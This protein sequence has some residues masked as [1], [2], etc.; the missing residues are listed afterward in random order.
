MQIRAADIDFW[1]ARIN[2][3][4]LN[5]ETNMY[6]PRVKM[7]ITMRN[8]ETDIDI[9]L[10]ITFEGCSSDSQLNTD[11][12]FPL[13]FPSLNL[14]STASSGSQVDYNSCSINALGE[15]KT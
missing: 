4:K 12:I 6:P 15:F 1:E 11:I 5:H 2:V 9:K 7:T 13:G 3:M 14:S 10:P 8:P